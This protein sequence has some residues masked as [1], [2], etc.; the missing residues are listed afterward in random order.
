MPCIYITFI[1][2]H[3]Y[4]TFRAYKI[5]LDGNR[6]HRLP[7]L[8]LHLLGNLVD[9][10]LGPAIGQHHH[11]FGNSPPHAPVRGKDAFLHVFDGPS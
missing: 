2:L 8:N 7:T 10:I 6:N 4:S 9:V 3:L 5:A 1:R 11:N